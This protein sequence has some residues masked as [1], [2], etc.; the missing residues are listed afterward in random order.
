MFQ[1]IISIINK[2][3][4]NGVK[5]KYFIIIGI[6]GIIVAVVFLIRFSISENSDVIYK[7]NKTLIL[8]IIAL[9]TKINNEGA[10][11]VAV[12]PTDRSNWSFEVVLDTHSMELGEDLT[13][14]SVLVDENGNEHKP[15]E[16]RGDP[17]GGHHRAGTLIFGEIASASKSV[18]LIIRQIGGIA[19]RKFEWVL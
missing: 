17:P 2:T 7:N 3:T 9:D 10:V 8:S 13:Q 19:E 18:I 11:T 6:V 4:S 1:Q 14:V 16:W 5:K 15:V 12:T